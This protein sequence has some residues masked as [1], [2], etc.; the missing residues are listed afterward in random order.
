[1]YRES[2]VLKPQEVYKSQQVLRV[3]GAFDQVR[4]CFYYAVHVQIEADLV[5][6][7]AIFSYKLQ[8]EPENFADYFKMQ[9]YQLH[10]IFALLCRSSFRRFQFSAE[11]SNSTRFIVNFLKTSSQQL[12][13]IM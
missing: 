8:D 9:H 1:M 4:F 3:F 13:N 11:S 12:E 2:C 5:T 10:N 7:V 6:L